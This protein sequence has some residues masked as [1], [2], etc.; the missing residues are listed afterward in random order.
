VEAQGSK[1][2]AIQRIGHLRVEAHIEIRAPIEQSMALVEKRAADKPRDDVGRIDD[3]G[4]D[5]R[6]VTDVYS[7]VPASRALTNSSTGSGSRDGSTPR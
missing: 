4:R 7:H 2:K 1:A 6:Y 5:G 3:K